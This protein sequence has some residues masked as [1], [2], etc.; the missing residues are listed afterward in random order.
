MKKRL[1]ALLM[2]TTM[3]AGAVGCGSTTEPAEETAT[4]EETTEE[5]EA[6][7]VEEEPVEVE[8]EVEEAAEVEETV[9]E[10]VEEVVEPMTFERNNY[11]VEVSYA[12]LEFPDDYIGHGDIVGLSTFNTN[13]YIDSEI[14]TELVNRG[15]D[16]DGFT[17]SWIVA[18]NEDGEAGYEEF[19][20]PVKYHK[21]EDTDEEYVKV[22]PLFI[23]DSNIDESRQVYDIFETS[24]WYF[25]ESYNNDAWVAINDAIVDMKADENFEEIDFHIPDVNCNEY[26]EKVAREREADNPISIHA[27]HEGCNP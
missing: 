20:E 25:K 9:E 13:D 11:E 5:A 26:F 14:M 24:P 21:F 7:E 12:N 27:P 10:E 1:L 2:A 23:K 15:Y 6:E 18:L 22:Y 3:A 8:E 19:S 17:V 16:I 4:V